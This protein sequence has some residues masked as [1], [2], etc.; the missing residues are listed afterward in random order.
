MLIAL[1]ETT[2]K[3]LLSHNCIRT[4]DFEKITRITVIQ[5]KPVLRFFLGEEPKEQL[6]QPLLW[7]THGGS[8]SQITP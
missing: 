6:R 2:L 7:Y 4:T 5:I 3:L 8:P 1:K